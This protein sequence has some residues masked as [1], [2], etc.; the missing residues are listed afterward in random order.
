MDI[1]KIISEEIEKF[2]TYAGYQPKKT[3][4]ENLQEQRVP[5]PIA[6]SS[7]NKANERLQAIANKKAEAAAN[8]GNIKL[9]NKTM[10]WSDYIVQ[11]NITDEEI[12]NAEKF[13]VA[14][15]AGVK[16]QQERFKNII[17]IRNT[18]DNNG[19]IRNPGSQYNGKSWSE[20]VKQYKVTPQEIAQSE[21]YTQKLGADA[22]KV[23]DKQQNVTNSYCSVKNGKI[24]APG[25][26]ND[27]VEWTKY[28]SAYKVTDA[29]IKTAVASC[30]TQKIGPVTSG[31]QRGGSPKSSYSNVNQKFT[32]SLANLGIQ[33][34]KMDIDTLNKI[35]NQLNQA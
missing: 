15:A 13:N 14:A 6:Y 31:V 21:Q 10:K 17:S 11:Y 12:K 25:Y 8:N 22:K 5:T 27:G 4:T 9:G 35:V 23:Q 33:G 20:Y 2:K 24:V 19:I 18:V 1:N 16:N 28:V 32:K 34:N 3:L 7:N 26:K 29:E 30:P